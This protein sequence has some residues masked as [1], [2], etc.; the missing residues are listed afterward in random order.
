MCRWIYF[1]GLEQ[2]KEDTAA[3]DAFAKVRRGEMIIN[4]VCEQ[5]DAIFHDRKSNC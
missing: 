2:R 5:S 3:L 4:E 1:H